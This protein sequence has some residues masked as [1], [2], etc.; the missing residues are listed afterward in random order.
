MAAHGTRLGY[1]VC[2]GTWAGNKY[3]TV[4]VN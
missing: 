1:G 2:S 3:A 4:V